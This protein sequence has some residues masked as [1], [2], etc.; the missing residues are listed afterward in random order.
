MRDFILYNSM[1][2]TFDLYR[3]KEKHREK[4]REKHQNLPR[5]YRD[6]SRHYVSIETKQPCIRS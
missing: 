4:H 2:C 5:G 3:N 1:E 6:D